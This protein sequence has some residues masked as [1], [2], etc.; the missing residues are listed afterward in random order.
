MS[1]R[2]DE[3]T[4]LAYVE[5]LLAPDDRLAFEA[6]L[7]QD[8]ALK[9]LMQQ[10][11]EDR[12]RLAAM[13][14]ESAPADLMDRVNHQLER[15]M[16]LDSPMSGPE[17]A[18][19][20]KRQNLGRWMVYSSVAAM[21]VV[22]LGTV[23]VIFRE[24]LLLPGQSSAPTTLSSLPVP[25]DSPAGMADRP[26]PIPLAGSVAAAATAP[27]SMAESNSA[28]SDQ[29][30]SES[31]K[32]V[33]HS[34]ASLALAKGERRSANALEESAQASHQVV[35]EG[36]DRVAHGR[37]KQEARV[38]GLGAM[39]DHESAVD[40]AVWPK[41]HIQVMTDDLAASQNALLAWAESLNLTV[42][43]EPKQSEP[44]SSLR[45]PAVSPADPLWN[46]QESQTGPYA[47]QSQNALT[48]H[49]AGTS[50]MVTYRPILLTLGANQ[51][52]RLLNHLNARSGQTARVI[53]SSLSAP[54]S[55]TAPASD[56]LSL[57]M[58]AQ[59]WAELLLAPL[60]KPQGSPVWE[61]S[62]P[63][64]LPVILI[65]SSPTAMP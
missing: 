38:S 51:V 15:Q 11:I 21:L 13:P 39:A 2:Y 9:M 55:S 24:T 37:F 54:S 65:Y 48:P 61:S 28:S 44:A 60:A 32:P 30:K 64:R 45:P 42:T 49:P 41:V 18:V 53:S 62:Q 17:L 3:S 58:T 19:P 5:Q 50:A 22:T 29:A 35:A 40:P 25:T 63:V 23:L 31:A 34:A 52:P 56:S 12:Q 10:L 27:M 26:S 7:D 46:I 4:I 1:E 6:L 47:Y 57:G 43:V 16:L 20:K 8:P 33:D 59:E 14:V 36:G